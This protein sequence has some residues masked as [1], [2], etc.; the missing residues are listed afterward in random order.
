MAKRKPLEWWMKGKAQGNIK[1]GLLGILQ[2]MET[3]EEELE[4]LDLQAEDFLEFC[5]YLS[6]ALA[7]QQAIVA[8]FSKKLKTKLAADRKQRAA[9][10]KTSR[11]KKVAKA[12]RKR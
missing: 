7:Q 5:S 6:E 9:S 10:K 1:S 8:K 11:P 12:T 3:F 2:S 4:T